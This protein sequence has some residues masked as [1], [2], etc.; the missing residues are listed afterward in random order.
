MPILLTKVYNVTP[1]PAH[2]CNSCTME[3]RQMLQVNVHFSSPP[4]MAGAPKWWACWN[5]LAYSF[6]HIPTYTSFCNGR[7]LKQFVQNLKLLVAETFQILCVGVIFHKG[8]LYLK[9]KFWFGPLS[10]GFQFEDDLISGWW[11]MATFIN[12][13]MVHFL[14]WKI[15]ICFQEKIE[16]HLQLTK[17]FQNYSIVS[18]FLSLSLSV[19][20]TIQFWI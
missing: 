2:H 3:H 12:R 11:D 8:C 1:V 5:F 16:A 20:Q 9:F 4:N 10:L 17:L 13:K 15:S 7:R 14:K 18:F 6:I 19:S